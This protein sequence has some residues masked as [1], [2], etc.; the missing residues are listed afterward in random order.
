[1]KLFKD[2]T[3]LALLVILVGGFLIRFYGFDNPIAD[4]HSWRQSETASVSRNF[5]QD[6]FDLLHPKMD[7]ISNVQSGMDNP[8][9]YFFVEFPIYNALQA[10]LYTIFGVFTIEQWGRLVSMVS[11]VAAGLFLYLIVKRY[12]NSTIG[13]LS[14][15]FYMFIPFNIFYGRAILPD[16]TMTM[17]FLGSIY[18]FDKYIDALSAKSNIKGIQKKRFY[19]F[20]LSTLFTI[21]A[22][23]LKPHAVF[24]LL[25]IVYLAFKSFG[26]STFKKWQLYIYALLSVAPLLAWRLWMTQYPEGIPSNLWLFN[27]NGIR[28]RPSFF[29]WIFYERLTVLISGYVGIILLGLGLLKLRALKEWAFF[30]TFLL[31][32]LLFVSIVATGNVQHDYYQIPAIPSVAIIMAVGSYYLSLWNIKKYPIGKILLVLIIFGSFYYSW[33]IVKEYFNINNR[34][35]LSAGEAV[36]RL[37]PEDSLIVANYNGD[38]AVIYQFNRKGWASYQNA[39]PELVKRGAD[40]LV[41]INPSEQENEQWK[42]EYALVEGTKQYSIFDLTKE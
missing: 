3:L 30:A 41:L 31:S 14:T 26:W 21:A 18:F 19:N 13:L 33:N 40:Y 4:W 38:S 32:T 23:L 2:T 36:Q 5:A 15:F 6:G 16:V 10:G 17:A 35:I 20:I 7:N 9:G 12:S 24:F 28:F 8:E 37:T 1:M 34:S 39:V 22:L 11:S 29:R 25:P 42:K 27:S